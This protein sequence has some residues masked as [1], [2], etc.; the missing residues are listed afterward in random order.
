[1]P[2][3]SKNTGN[4][5]LYFENE[6][7]GARLSYNYRSEYF[8]DKDRGRDLYSDAT[9]SLDLSINVHL[10]D[11]FAVTFDG[12]NLLDEELFQYYDNLTSRPARYYD[13]GPIYYL[14]VRFNF[15]GR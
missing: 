8:I 7:F 14:G 10:T 15:D 11:N 6:R 4:A 2:G 5:T 12:V 13:N 1:M 3:N 9:D